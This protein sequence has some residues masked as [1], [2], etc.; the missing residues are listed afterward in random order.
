MFPRIHSTVE[1]TQ[2]L[3]RY[4]IEKNASLD[5]SKLVKHMK[6]SAGFRYLRCNLYTKGRNLAF[7][8]GIV[9]LPCIWRVPFKPSYDDSGGLT[10][11]LHTE[12]SINKTS[13]P[14]SSYIKFFYLCLFHI[15]LS[16]YLKSKS[17]SKKKYYYHKSFISL[18]SVKVLQLFQEDCLGRK[19]NHSLIC[20]LI[21][22]LEK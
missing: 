6:C 21:I 20:L 15:S 10:C 12:I 2:Q 18:S 9:T 5:I 22:G 8:A 3:K 11:D 16:F 13:F 14:L 4:L 1:C 19:G 17:L 7:P